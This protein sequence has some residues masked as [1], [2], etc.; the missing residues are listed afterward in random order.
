MHRA[1]AILDRVRR[2]EKIDAEVF[3]ELLELRAEG[4]P[5]DMAGFRRP[6][7]IAVILDGHHQI[8]NLLPDDTHWP[9]KWLVSLLMH[10]G[11]RPDEG[12][13]GVVV[14]RDEGIDVRLELF[15]ST[16][17]A[18]ARPTD[19]RCRK[20]FRRKILLIPLCYAAGL[21]R[22]GWGT[23][24]NAPALFAEL[25]VL[26]VEDDATV[27]NL[28][29]S[30]LRR[31]RVAATVYAE[32]GKQGLQL[33][34]A[35]PTTFDLVICDWNMPVMTGLE[36]CTQVRADRPDLPF[37]MVTG[38]NDAVSVKT[39]LQSGVSAYIVKPFSPLELKKKI[40]ILIDRYRNFE[41]I[42][43]SPN[44]LVSERNP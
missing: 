44:S 36:L 34:R 39:A 17:F 40:A 24:M 26:V 35:A 16:T 15:L 33:F 38:R 19:A 28:I 7:K 22:S 10:L 14:G 11:F 4:R 43:T 13:G 12:F 32:D 18:V 27:R 5:A 3:F 2:F 20:S 21:V 6:A 31:L 41:P 29:C 30:M 8:A 9:A 42:A 23:W 37:L 25:T 1:F